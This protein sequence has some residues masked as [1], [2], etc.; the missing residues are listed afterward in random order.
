M[1]TRLTVTSPVKKLALWVI[2]HKF[3]YGNC[4]PPLHVHLVSTR[5]N[6]CDNCSQAFPILL[7]LCTILNINRRPKH[8]TGEAW[9]RGYLNHSCINVLQLVCGC[10]NVLGWVVTS[11]VGEG[12]GDGIG[13]ERA[14]VFFSSIVTAPKVERK[15]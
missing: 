8:S 15:Q 7:L 12:E 3:V 5:H 1:F 6:S 14:T 2:A 13:V 9:E 10:G 11:G 4:P